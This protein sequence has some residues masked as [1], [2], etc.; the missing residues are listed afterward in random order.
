VKDNDPSDVFETAPVT[1][2]PQPVTS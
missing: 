1:A 2:L